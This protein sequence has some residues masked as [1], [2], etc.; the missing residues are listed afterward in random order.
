MTK[1]LV[2]LLTVAGCADTTPFKPHAH[3]EKPLSPAVI[4][5]AYATLAAVADDTAHDNIAGSWARRLQEQGKVREA[6]EVAGRIRN[7][8]IRGAVLAELGHGGH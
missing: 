4:D 5:D 1:Y 6:V 7:E 2:L 8:R 3:E